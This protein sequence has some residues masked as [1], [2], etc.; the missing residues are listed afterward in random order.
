MYIESNKKTP[1]LPS[2][3]KWLG[4]AF[5]STPAIFIVVVFFV[6]PFIQS[7]LT[8][9]KSAD[10]AWTIE[11]YTTA[12]S[13]YKG[14][15]WYTL[16]VC[17][18]SLVILLFLSVLLGG[19]LRLSA[20]SFVEFLFK[21]PLFVPFVVVGHAMRV[22]LA[23]H[24]TMNSLLMSLGLFN[25]DQVPSLAFTTVGLILALVWKNIGLSLLL[26]LGAFRAVDNSYLEAAKNAGAGN[27]RLIKDILMPMCR[28][29]I[30]VVAVLTFTSMMGSFS[31]PVMLGNSSGNQMLMIDLYYQLVYQQDSGVANAIGVI[32]YLVSMGA[33]IYYV[34][35]VSKV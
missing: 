21:I 2:M 11:N 28:G 18:V 15:F 5:L 33:A 31:I 29:S 9:L 14:D 22:F 24:G 17:V 13:L 30:G 35:R 7:V 3:L 25:P 23:P 12:I 1:F 34:R 4:G 19:F 27:F 26:T 20:N 6:Y 16:W 10:G 32:S 8:S